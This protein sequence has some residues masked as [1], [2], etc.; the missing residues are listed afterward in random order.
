MVSEWPDL[1]ANEA[2]DANG[3]EAAR[4]ERQTGANLG[5]DQF[6]GLWRESTACL[7]EGYNTRQAEDGCLKAESGQ[8]RMRGGDR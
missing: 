1:A 3:R 7:D 5:L 4:A 8:R 6:Q 2:S